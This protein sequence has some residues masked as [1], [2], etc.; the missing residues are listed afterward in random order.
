MSSVNSTQAEK[1]DRKDIIEKIVAYARKKVNVDEIKVLTAFIKQYFSNVPIEDLI[2]R[3]IEYLFGAVSSHWALLKERDP[4]Q[5]KIQV[6]NPS[7]EENGWYSTHTIV[8]VVHDDIPFLVDSL[9]MAINRLGYT[10]HLIIHSGGMKVRRNEL[11]VL[12]TLFPQGSIIKEAIIEALI[13]FEIDKQT[14]P[15]VLSVIKE[16]LQ[17]VLLDVCLA[18]KDWQAMKDQVIQIL[19]D[20]KE[21]EPPLDPEDFRESKAFLKWLINDHFTFLGSREYSVIEVDGKKALQ[22]IPQTGLGVLR[23]EDRSKVIRYFDELP[24]KARKQALSKQRLII[25]KT[26]TISTVHRPAYTDYIGVKKFNKEGEIVGLTLI[27]GLYTSD[28]YN[29]KLC[30]IPLVRRKVETIL[31]KSGLTHSPHDLKRLLNILN[32]FPRDD[33]F[34]G[35]VDLLCETAVGIF[36]LQD[37]KKTRLFV[38]PD[39]YGR[40]LSCLVY[41]P[42]DNLS[43]DLIYRMQSI[44]VDGFNGKEV[45][46]TIYFPESVLIRIHYV[47]RIDP[48]KKISYNLKEIEDKLI[49]VGRSWQDGLQEEIIQHYGEEVGST[50]FNRYRRAFP[51]GYREIYLPR[52]AIYDIQY[53]EKLS[54]DHDLALSIYRPLSA[55]PK[56]LRLKLYRLNNAIPLSDTLPILEHMGLRVAEEQPFQVTFENSANIAWINDFNIFYNTDTPLNIDE[57]NVIFQDAFHHIWYGHA[58]N[59]GFNK[60]VLGAK[61]TWREISV[62][63]AYAKYLR[64]IGF[65]FSQHYIE[66]T[67][68]KN[69]SVA[70]LFMDLFNQTFNPRIHKKVDKIRSLEEKLMNALDS[71][72]NLDEDRILRRYLEVMKATLRTNYF[73]HTEE[74]SFK[75]YISFKFNSS[76]I[77]DI[78]LP[79]PMFET[80]V[81]S[82]EFEG[83]HL[84]AGK[85]ARGGLRWSNRR[86]DFRTEILGLMKAQQVKNAIIVPSG[87]KGGFVVKNLPVDA[88]REIVMECGV[89]CYKNFIRG[90]LDLA[91]NLVGSSIIRPKDTVCFDDE[92]P[93]LVVAADKGTATFSDIANEISR[94]YGFWLD[95]AFASGGSTGYDHKKIGITARGAWESVKCHFRILNIDPYHEDFTVVGIGDMAGDVF[96]NG[97]LYTD[98][99]KL[100]A[101][102]NHTHIFIDPNP[103]PK[104]SYF[105]RLH[106]FKLPAS[107]WED[108]DPHLISKGGGVFSRSVKLIKL[109]PEARLALGVTKEALIPSELIKAILKAPV[110]LLWNGGIGTFVKSCSETQNEIGDRANDTL[111]I[112]G[113]ELRCK[114]VAE[115]GNL[116]FTQLGRI[117]YEL[118]G[119]KINTDFID[120]SG[121]VDCSDHEVNIKIFLSLLISEGLLNVKK[122]NSV[123]AQMTDEVAQLVLYN[124]YCQTRAI[125]FAVSTSMEYLELYRLFMHSHELNGN[126]NRALEFLPDDKTINERKANDLGLTRPEIAVLM[127]YSK[128]ILKNEILNSVLPEE[129]SLAEYIESAFPLTL[130]KRYANQMPRHHLSR[131]IIATQISNRIVTEMGITFVYQMNDENDATTEEIVRAYMTAR[132][133]FNLGALWNQVESL[134]HKVSINVL[135]EMIL[136]IMR[137]GRR[138]TRWLL[139]NKRSSFGINELVNHF[140]VHLSTL[141]GLFQSLLSEDER[142]KFEERI[143][144]LISEGVPE[145]IARKISATR[146]LYSSL[147]IIEAAIAHHVN[148]AQVAKIY[149]KLMERLEL[150]WFREKINDYPVENHWTVLARADYKGDLD[151]LQRVLTVSVIKFP[152]ESSRL[153]NKVEQ[154]F[155][156][157]K[158]Y[159]AR[160]KSVLSELRSSSTNEFVMLTV[161]MRGLL[162]L[163]QASR[164][165]EQK[166]GFNIM[167]EL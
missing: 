158:K 159:I 100:I 85:V 135:N 107:S 25:S 137:L 47:V 157:N 23:N 68:S 95:D 160:W 120:N 60:L 116:G 142:Q 146:P 14:D 115:G 140:S 42:R 35:S 122:R 73:Q 103:D 134:E 8:Q 154:W 18:V 16:D 29:S 92:D 22:L 50:L 163:A 32:T 123:L 125:S 69:P 89:F 10:I 165:Q 156:S 108:Y 98:R 145:D 87:A 109:S 126:L 64:Q 129:K 24:L 82:T 30:D 55:K 17:R 66:E 4:H 78:P 54:P 33:V 38:L 88:T 113:N 74:D 153:D 61:L 39:I 97:M 81:Y 161:A 127:A 105:E 52:N 99:I 117:E 40:Y 138:A 15:N 80:F 93:Y 13:Y 112:N 91:D 139:L 102:F 46:F 7:I 155:E 76:L 11:G 118:S 75:P 6:F 106:L 131:E 150:I 121:G 86:E 144:Y 148:V 34:Q 58:E 19:D 31:Q 167:Q 56:N 128:I 84:R 49:E 1:I 136:D 48:K 147:N 94:E 72:A 101:A 26:N 130:C 36:H 83:V 149:F 20:M 77:S 79:I 110:D 132:K 3:N 65:T 104:L 133:L 2:E 114:V 111:R 90:L 28:V 71:V 152:S 162:E 124:N 41:I 27:I 12:T 119:G 21:L 57:I 59:D 63:R 62:L 5:P 53:L 51:A 151:Y 9:R 45:T 143:V 44:L 96:G 70:R 141:E 67:F 37:R 164:Q 43:T 166:E